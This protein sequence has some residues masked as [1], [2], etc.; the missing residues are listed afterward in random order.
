M[1][2]DTLPLCPCSAPGFA[3]QAGTA[4][5]LSPSAAAAGTPQHLLSTP[6]GALLQPVTPPES[7]PMSPP[8]RG[9][10]KVAMP[11]TDSKLFRNAR[12]LSSQA[13][14][15]LDES[16]QLKDVK[17][18]LLSCMPPVKMRRLILFSESH[19]HRQTAYTAPECH[20]KCPSAAVQARAKPAQPGRR[21]GCRL[22]LKVCLY[23]RA[24]G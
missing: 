7:P 6:P 11:Q 14:Q 9:L 20:L 2:A 8:R 18:G 16:E 13:A 12:S 1:M 5:Q 22:R 10:E 19:L 4:A 15:Q 17:P 23:A 3:G 24:P 21:L